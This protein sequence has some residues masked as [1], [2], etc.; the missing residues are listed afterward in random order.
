MS[1]DQIIT[2][3]IGVAQSLA[4]VLIAYVVYRQ[5]EKLKRIEISKQAID[6]YNVLN[7]IAVSSDAN[8]LA[9]DKMGR[10]DIEE[11]IEVRR[12]RWCA[13]VWLEALQATFLSMKHNLIDRAYAEQALRQQLEVI[14]K[15]EDVY[16]L[17]CNRGFDPSF[18]VYCTEL[19]DRLLKPPDPPVGDEAIS[20]SL[21]QLSQQRE[22]QKVIKPLQEQAAC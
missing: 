14:L 13:F 17:V 16:W 15:D 8:L 1:F 5:T 9:F 19:R 7:G 12:K 21:S 10:S 4:M 11:D 20:V 3:T 6:S 22:V 18:A 2:L